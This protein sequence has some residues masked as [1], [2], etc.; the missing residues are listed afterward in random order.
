MPARAS[1]A[2]W[3][4]ER[5]S[6]IEAD[7]A[8]PEMGGRR[9]RRGWSRWRPLRRRRRLRAAAGTR[10][11]RPRARSPSPG[12]PA[13][14][15]GARSRGRAAHLR[16]RP[17]IC[18]CALGFLH[19][20]DRLWQMELTRRTGQGRLSEMFGERT[21]TT[22]VFLRTLDLYGHA[23]RV[24]GGALPADARKA[25]KPTR[26]ASTPSSTARP[27]CS[28]RGCRPEFLLLRHEPEPWRVGRQHRH[29]K[30]MALNLSTN[31]NL[32][33]M[34]LALA[35]QGLTSAEIEDLMPREAHDVPAAA[36][37]ARRALSAPAPN[38]RTSA[39]RRRAHRR[40]HRRRRLQ[41]LG[42]LGR[43]YALGQAA[44]GQ[45]SA[46]AAERACH[47]VSRPPGARA[48]RAPPPL[49]VVGATLAGRAARRARPQRHA[50]VG[51]HQHRP[52]R[53]GPLHREDQ[54][55]RPQAST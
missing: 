20:Q 2:W 47:L 8:G 36:A 53:A 52:R 15:G 31:L 16:P 11:P 48:A 4:S 54:P 50:G 29:R 14:R 7:E 42:R 30:M 26:A 6:G 44:A 35:A 3:C 22:D 37:R 25:S 33:M 40:P 10:C 51:F 23:E 13:R 18:F 41:Q 39:G 55:R 19:A 5:S 24:A 21:F 28:S 45:R 17:R 38:R 1:A 27:G 32:E 46:P 12:S 9:W 43:A 34:R 49:N